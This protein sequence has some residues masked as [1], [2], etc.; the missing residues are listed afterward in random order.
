MQGLDEEYACLVAT[1]IDGTI[2]AGNSDNGLTG[3]VV[4]HEFLL[5]VVP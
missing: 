3:K 4:R 5:Y 2:E 1:G